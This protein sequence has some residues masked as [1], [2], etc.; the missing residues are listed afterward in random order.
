VIWRK[1]GAY[2][3]AGNLLKR[4]VDDWFAA[5]DPAVVPAAINQLLH[6]N[7]RLRDVPADKVEHMQIM[8]DSENM[9]GAIQMLPIGSVAPAPAGGAGS[10]APAPAP[11]APAGSGVSRAVAAVAGGAGNRAAARV[12]GRPA[13]AA[14]QRDDEEEIDYEAEFA[15]FAVGGAVE[16]KLAGYRDIRELLIGTFGSIET[17][18]RYYRG[19]RGVDFL[20]KKPMVHVAT[21]GAQL[22]KAEELMKAKEKDLKDPAWHTDLLPSVAAVGGFNV[23]RN[24]NRPSALSDH[25]FGWAI[26][27]DAEENPNMYERFPGRALAAVT[28]EQM[29]AGTMGTIGLGGTAEELLAPIE[30]VRAASR[31]FEAAFA[32]E[33]ALTR[34]MRD[35]LVT[36]LKFDIAP[37][38]PLL[39]MVKAAAGAGK[40]GTKARKALSDLLKDH[41]TSIPDAEKFLEEAD[42]EQI[43]AN[44]GWDA[45][46]AE[47]A[48][49]DKERERAEQKARGERA[50]AAAKTDKLRKAGKSEDEIRKLVDEPHMAAR[51]KAFEAE[52]FAITDKA[53]GT[54]IE[55]WKIYVSSF[56]GGKPASGRRVA[57]SSEGT[58]GTV[59]AHGF[60]NMPGKLAAALS[61]SDGGGLDWLGAA[62]ARDFMHF[63]LKPAAR[64]PLT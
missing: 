4:A 47:K 48:R 5:L 56:E 8:A 59:A 44:K 34:A 38:V 35:Y 6:Q 11:P 17:A 28:G 45:W 9:R 1:G 53:A 49:R 24:R 39:D 40:A 3:Q 14:L 54:L 12:L 19:V 46:K 31:A 63:Q 7:Y 33:A 10:G 41:W 50:A 36:R 29:F 64:P 32:D 60:M 18:N 42:R 20:G 62:G 52:L 37:D 61:G 21:L 55:L 2:D 57:A 15:A 30:E 43:V 22:V 13:R 16:G 23:R 26:D 51:I 25:S 27:V 58:A